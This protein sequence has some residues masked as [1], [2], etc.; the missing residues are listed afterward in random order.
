MN[1]DRKGDTDKQGEGRRWRRGEEEGRRRR[2]KGVN[3]LEIE[4][5]RER[6]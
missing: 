1:G 4:A 6:E 5:G 3:Q 2:K